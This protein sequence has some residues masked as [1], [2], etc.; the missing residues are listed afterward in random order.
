MDSLNRGIVVGWQS[1]QGMQTCSVSSTCLL[2]PKEVED[3]ADSLYLAHQQQKQNKHTLV[4]A[5]Q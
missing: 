3:G 1:E 5:G 2:A 4:R